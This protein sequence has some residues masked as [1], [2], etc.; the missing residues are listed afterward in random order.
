MKL[1]I[2]KE[3]CFL[4]YNNNKKKNMQKVNMR[5]QIKAIEFP[6]SPEHYIGVHVVAS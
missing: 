1:V 2:E 5:E 4:V 6:K 3:T